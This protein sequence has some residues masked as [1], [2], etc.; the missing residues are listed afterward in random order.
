MWPR[1]RY[2][3]N[4]FRHATDGS[5]SCNVIRSRLVPATVRRC[6][7]LG[8]HPAVDRTLRNWRTTMSC[9]LF[10]VPRAVRGLIAV[11]IAGVLGT[12]IWVAATSTGGKP[13]GPSAALVPPH[14]TPTGGP[15]SSAPT[16][17]PSPTPGHPLPAGGP[18]R[19][20]DANIGSAR[21][22]TLLARREGFGR[23]VTGGAGGHVV[24]VS[25]AADSGPGSLRAALA[26]KRPAWVVFDGD[27]TIGFHSGVPVAANKTIDGR[28]HVVTLTG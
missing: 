18:A 20:P 26:D 15:P 3:L 22:P 23:G 9:T 21:E 27:Y 1:R 13:H 4:C 5:P 24:H 7:P 14:P 28:G 8:Q 17:R 12:G 11:V 10:G 6:C 19:K 2:A 16:A 25:S